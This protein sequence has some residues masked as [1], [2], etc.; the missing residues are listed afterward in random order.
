MG[1]E[2]AKSDK[3]KSV[4]AGELADAQAEL[5]KL[6]KQNADGVKKARAREEQLAES[7]SKVEELEGSLSDMTAKAGKNAAEGASTHKLLEESEHTLGLSKK[8]VKNL[9]SQLAEARE[10]T[11]AESKAKHDISLKLRNMQGE[12]EKMTEDL[13]EEGS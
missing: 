5:D 7:R 3:N 10:E 4:V 13:E 1:K 11:E 8:A 9:E 2:K 6:K 12:L